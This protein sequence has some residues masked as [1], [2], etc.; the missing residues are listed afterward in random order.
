MKTKFRKRLT[1]T[2]IDVRLLFHFVG[3]M[4]TVKVFGNEMERQ[5]GT[6]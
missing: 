2:E 3:G 4:I 5:G 6:Q 1:F